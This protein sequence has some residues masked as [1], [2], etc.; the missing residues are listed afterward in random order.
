MTLMKNDTTLSQNQDCSPNTAETKV[1]Q[2]APGGLAISSDKNHSESRNNNILEIIEKFSDDKALMQVI[3]NAKTQE[4]KLL[5]ERETR[6]AEEIR[7]ETKKTELEII[8]RKSMIRSVRYQAGANYPNQ[9]SP[10]FYN[11]PASAYPDINSHRNFNQMY[12][13]REDTPETSKYR[14]PQRDSPY[15]DEN[16]PQEYRWNYHDERYVGQSRYNHIGYSESPQRSQPYRHNDESSNRLTSAYQIPRSDSAHDESI[17]S[18]PFSANIHHESSKYSTDR[19]QISYRIKNVSNNTYSNGDYIPPHSAG[20][21]YFSQHFNH[22]K[23]LYKKENFDCPPKKSR[24]MYTSHTAFE[25]HPKSARIEYPENSPPFRKQGHSHIDPNSHNHRQLNTGPVLGNQ[26]SGFSEDLEA[27]ATNINYTNVVQT[28]NP[29]DKVEGS[30][31]IDYLNN[32][33]PLKMRVPVRSISNRVI[34]RAANLVVQ[35]KQEQSSKALKFDRDENIYSAPADLSSTKQK[36]VRRQDVI[37]ALRR[38]IFNVENSKKNNDPNFKQYNPQPLT[39]T[40]SIQ[41][42]TNIV[43]NSHA[44]SIAPNT[45]IKISVNPTENSESDPL[46]GGSSDKTENSK[47]SLQKSR[48]SA[49]TGSISLLLEAGKQ[50][51]DQTQSPEN[52]DTFKRHSITSTNSSQ[53]ISTSSAGGD[54]VPNSDF[55]VALTHSEND[56]NIVDGSK[57]KRNSKALKPIEIQTSRTLE[58]ENNPKRLREVSNSQKHQSPDKPEPTLKKTAKTPKSSKTKKLSSKKPTSPTTDDSLPSIKEQE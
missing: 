35:T 4:N 19:D 24:M 33:M 50:S 32:N 42:N 45:N 11:V 34:N 1:D 48:F 31:S 37:Q 55:H 57:R 2:R 36:N 51:Y 54:N 17:I 26:Y 28:N 3:I 29:G 44:K 12:Q 15:P 22:E 14:H 53:S 5:T 43:S 46:S 9:N 47:S 52:V 40:T 39:S 8:K 16:Y 13:A 49:S 38:K 25:N 27:K 6:R 18:H 20:P 10:S 41:P 23:Y 21:K 56:S 30:D 7:L 58:S